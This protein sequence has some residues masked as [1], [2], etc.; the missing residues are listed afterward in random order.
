[1]NTNDG[2]GVYQILES[3]ELDDTMC[4]VGRKSILGDTSVWDRDSR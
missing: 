4:K 2:S 3:T 1:M